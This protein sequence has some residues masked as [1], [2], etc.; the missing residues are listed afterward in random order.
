MAAIKS[1]L[2]K[3]REKQNGKSIRPAY[4]C[5]VSEKKAGATKVNAL[6]YQQH[7]KTFSCSAICV[8]IH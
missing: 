2:K 1:K 6:K 5:P 3:R 8:T 7:S 4:R